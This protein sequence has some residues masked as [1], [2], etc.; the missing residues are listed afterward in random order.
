[1]S[2]LRFKIV[3]TVLGTPRF[4]I[5]TP[6]L[7]LPV[8]SRPPSTGRGEGLF[9]FEI[10]GNLIACSI[11]AGVGVLQRNGL[12]FATIVSAAVPARKRLAF[13]AKSLHLGNLNFAN[14]QFPLSCTLWMGLVGTRFI[15]RDP[16]SRHLAYWN[17]SSRRSNVVI[18]AK[19]SSEL[20]DAILGLVLYTEVQ[21]DGS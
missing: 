6:S 10:A 12:E 9:S 17:R 4:C 2:A 15:L 5:E 16:N 11:D 13:R 18:S 14:Q 1:M 20:R 21:K 8:K 3:L 7:T 19:A